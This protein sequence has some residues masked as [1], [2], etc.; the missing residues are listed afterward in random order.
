MILLFINLLVTDLIIIYY[1]Q[2]TAIATAAS[3]NCTVCLLAEPDWKAA[4]AEAPTLAA[5]LSG[6]ALMCFL[7]PEVGEAVLPAG[8]SSLEIITVME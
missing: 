2:P 3:W 7:K 5:D 6:L 1:I 8:S 4:V